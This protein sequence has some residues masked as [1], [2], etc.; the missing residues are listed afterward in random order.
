MT[1]TVQLSARGTVVSTNAT[2]AQAK[3]ITGVGGWKR[4]GGALRRTFAAEL[5]WAGHTATWRTPA[6]PAAVMSRG[7][8]IP[9]D[10]WEASGAVL[11][12]LGDLGEPVAVTVTLPAGTNRSAAVVAFLTAVAAV[13]VS[14]VES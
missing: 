4:S 14:A 13:E 3:D 11:E 10:V 12:A 6:E 8:R 1:T 9:P 2:G 7:V 5:E